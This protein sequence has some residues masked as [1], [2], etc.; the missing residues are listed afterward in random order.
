M[1]LTVK[2]TSADGS[3]RVCETGEGRVHLCYRA[4]YEEGDILC[5]TGDTPGCLLVVQ[6]EDSMPPAFACLGG[7]GGALPVPF[8]EQR[9]SYSPKSFTGD[10]HLLSARAATEE[11][12]RRYKNLAFNPFDCHG[13]KGLYPHAHANVET[14]GEAVFA[15][16]NAING[17][18][19]NH[20]HG[21]WPFESWGVN[22]RADAEIQVDFGRTVKVDRAVI[23]LRADFPHDNWWQRGTLRFS[24]G[25]SEELRFAKGDGPQATDFAPRLIEWAA[26]CGLEKCP[27]DTSPF[28][29]LTQLELWGTEA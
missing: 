6:L 9:V 26:L 1:Q 28:P 23:T 12:I 19:A 7:A 3:P 11:E 27:D 14:R 25:S 22:Q 29:A 20:S 17:N 10:C 13:N 5:V 18:T 16:R 21:A 8:G 15:A 4:A 2:V 24:D